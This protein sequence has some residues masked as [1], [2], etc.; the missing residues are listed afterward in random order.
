MHMPENLPDYFLI[1]TQPKAR[2]TPTVVT[3]ACRQIKRNRTQYLRDIPTEQIITI[4]ARLSE[5]WRDEHFPFRKLALE[6]CPEKTGFSHASLTH[7]M[8]RFFSRIT[9]DSLY[10]LMTQEFGDS[11][12]IDPNNRNTC[13]TDFFRGRHAGF[14]QDPQRLNQAGGA[15]GKY[16]SQFGQGGASARFGNRRI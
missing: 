9:E 1:D 14:H 11:R 13:F 6:L 5:N 8:D 10:N 12:R 2:I 16:R 15:A 7:G 3:E 4:I